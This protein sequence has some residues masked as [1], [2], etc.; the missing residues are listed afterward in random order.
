MSTSKVEIPPHTDLW[1]TGSLPGK[2]THLRK[3]LL[4]TGIVPRTAW[5]MTAKF[6][7]GRIRKSHLKAG[8]SKLSRSNPL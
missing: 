6:L 7:V 2:L 4:K 3:V 5:E 8:E 1:D